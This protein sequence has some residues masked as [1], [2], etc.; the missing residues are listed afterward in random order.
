MSALVIGYVPCAR[1]AKPARRPRVL[2][3]AC[4]DTPVD[5]A[6]IR[7]ELYRLDRA[8]YFRESM[9]RSRARRR[10]LLARMGAA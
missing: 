10:D 6:F 1:C 2:C 9:R 7:R 5:P 4:T 3:L 8:A